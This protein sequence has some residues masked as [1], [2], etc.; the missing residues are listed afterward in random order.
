MLH[1][2]SV[3]ALLALASDAGAQTPPS[4]TQVAAYDGLHLAAH[5][6]D[7]TTIRELAAA[8]ADPDVRDAAGRTPAHVAAFASEDDALRALA[9]AGADLNA[10]EG[11]AY[12]VVTIA[13]VAND[14]ELMSLAIELGNDPGLTTSPYDGTA[15]IAAVR[16]ETIWNIFGLDLERRVVLRGGIYHNHAKPNGIAARGATAIPLSESPSHLLWK[17]IRCRPGPAR[18]PK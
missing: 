18:A 2:F 17:K 11:Q 6:G 8:G 15:L 3:I 10:L 1:A 12:D 4:P 9:A 16:R 14:P 7:V 5:Q 13:A